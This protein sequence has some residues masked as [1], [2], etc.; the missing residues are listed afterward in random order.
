MLA[1]AALASELDA[2]IV[3][4][5]TEPE[6]I[7]AW[8]DSIG[9]WFEGATANAVA[10][11]PAGIAPATAALKS[12]LV[13]LSAT[14]SAALVA[15]LT[16]FWAALAS[17]PAAVFPAATLIVP[18]PTIGAAQAA[19]DAVFAANVAAELS[20]ADALNAV[21][22]A[23]YSNAFVGGTATFPLPIGVVPIL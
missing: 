7:T 11:L 19:L 5:E 13:G 23:I 4:V 8:G 15:G 3:I 22:T 18:P 21:A 2:N 20:Q 10:A 17:A 1:A 12:G 16:A 6:A 9:T 14:G